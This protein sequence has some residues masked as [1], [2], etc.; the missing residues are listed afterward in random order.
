[1]VF[2]RIFQRPR[3]RIV[4]LFSTVLTILCFVI[5]LYPMSTSVVQRR[6]ETQSL[7]LNSRRS[8]YYVLNRNF[9]EFLSRTSMECFIQV[10][11]GKEWSDE[12]IVKTKLIDHDGLQDEQFTDTETADIYFT[13]VPKKAD[14]FQKK[15]VLAYR[16]F[17][18]LGKTMENL[19]QLAAVAKR[20][21]RLVI[22][23]DVKNSRFSLEPGIRAYP[24]DAYFNV[25]SLNKLLLE[26][27][28]SQ[29]VSLNN[30]IQ[31]CSYKN[32]GVKTT[33]IHFLYS[34][35]HRGNTKLWFGISDKELREIVE[36]SLS[37]GWTECDFIN[38]QLSV[39]T[40]LD[41]IQIGRQVCVNPEVVRSEK[42]FEDNVLRG[43]KC[44]IFL[45]WRGFGKL[46]THF[47]PNF[48]P[49]LTPAEVKHRIS[50][51]NLIAQ[52]VISFVESKLPSTYISVHLRTERLFVA[53]LYKKLQFCIDHVVHLVSI[54]R[55]LRGA[56]KVFL[57]TDVND[58]GSDLFD[59]RTFY[60]T[61][62]TGEH[63]M[64]RQD[65][66]NIHTKLARRLNAVTYKPTHIPFTKDKGIFS[67]VEMSILKQGTDL[68][69]L[70]FGTFHAWTVSVFRQH[71]KETG[72]R[73]YTISE[74]C[75]N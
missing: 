36:K 73:G 74:I 63:L 62:A 16:H 72:L 41:G 31:G 30:F 52:E 61:N 27:G 22:Q 45:E 56:D 28:Y 49:N 4:L 65:I 29:L 13:N 71:Q 48:F 69:T 38:R 23:P 64:T 35:V 66:A 70:G 5:V 59:R 26:N 43:D 50:P 68:I 25:T 8:E 58:F 18:Q 9:F 11:P 46:R 7:L 12:A 24:L 57:A 44:V 17:E 33:L 19:I 42:A 3:T 67:L 53:N 37:S 1:M 10:E 21:G 2:R 34:D 15:Y 20:W 51:S 6:F 39:S 75:G 40:S 60:K 32:V 14:D 55:S 47:H 54:I